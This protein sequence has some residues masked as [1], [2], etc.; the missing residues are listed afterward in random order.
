VAEQLAGLVAVVPDVVAADE[1]PARGG[2]EQAAH[3]LDSRRLAGPVGAEK[4]EQLARPHLQAEFLHGGLGAVPLGDFV[5]SDHGWMGPWPRKAW[6]TWVTNLAP[7]RRHLSR[8]MAQRAS[9]ASSNSWR[10]TR[11]S[12]LGPT[13]TQVWP[14]TSSPW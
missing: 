12:P 1:H 8:W 9:S 6:G 13:A 2:E 10:S 7:F 3:H 4:G 14:V 11:S 5:E